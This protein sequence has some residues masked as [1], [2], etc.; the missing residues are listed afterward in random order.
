MKRPGTAKRIKCD[1]ER[2]SNCDADVIYCPVSPESEGEHPEAPLCLL[3]ADT[4]TVNSCDTIWAPPSPDH[5]LPKAIASRPQPQP[6][7]QS[8][9]PPPPPQPRRLLPAAPDALPGRAVES[10]D[11]EEEG[12]EAVEGLVSPYT[13]DE[14]R[15]IVSASPRYPRPNNGQVNGYV[16][17]NWPSL[18]PSRRPS[19]L[20]P[21]PS[22]GDVED[23]TANITRSDSRPSVSTLAMTWRAIPPAPAGTVSL[24]SIEGFRASASSP[25]SMTGLPV[26]SQAASLAWT[27]SEPPGMLPPQFGFQAKMDRTDRRL[28]EFYIKNWCPGRSVLRDTNLWLKDLAPM[29]GNEGILYAIQS[30]SGI[31]I[32]DYMPL[33]DIRQRINQRYDMANQYYSTLLH[34][35]ESRE[36]GKGQEVITMTALLSMLDIVLTERRLKKPYNPRWLEGFR[37][38]EYFLQATDPGA[39][40][41]KNNNVQYNELRISQ[42]IIVGRAVILAQLMMALPSPQTFN[43]GAEAGRFSWLLYGTEKDMYEIHG[44]CGFSKKL[45]HLMSQVTYC[46]GRLQ[47]EPESTIVPITAKFLLRELS[48]M[49]QWS[50]EGKDWELAR[51]YPPTIDWVRDRADEIIIDS[52]QIMTEVTAE[53]WRIAAI[54][55]YQCRLLRLPRNHPEVLANLDDLA[56]CIRIMPTSG[57]HFTAQAPLLPV[58][59]LGLLATETVHKNVSMDWF[60]Q[61]VQTP[62]RSSVPS[63]Y[64]ALLRIWGWIDKEVQIPRD[65]TALSKDIGK[66]YPWW[67]H[68]VAKVLEAEEEILCLT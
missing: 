47:Q 65:P 41:W 2:D 25:I 12:G 52:N 42:S 53:A 39:R 26:S 34:A 11:S 23:I 6:Q 64:D 57:S 8:Q 56:L 58:F 66:R 43:P 7:L 4:V 33:E 40:Y 18:G 13:V 19:E 36:V 35:P 16:K 5:Q 38:G 62:V 32:Y 22:E 44:G 15:L 37:Q 1:P 10:Q 28:F 31:Y 61:V 9:P 59:F 49:R 54:I 20:L 29:H 60:E 68:L 55:Y 14:D 24:S 21:L 27:T 3:K 30:L 63:L 46:A 50:R 51:K 67:E 45:L 48:E 17:F